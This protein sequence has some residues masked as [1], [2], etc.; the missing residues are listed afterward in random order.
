M[1]DEIDEAFRPTEAN[2]CQADARLL[3]FCRDL[4]A[5]T[6]LSSRYALNV[7]N[8]VGCGSAEQERNKDTVAVAKTNDS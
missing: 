7:G 4:L 1:I 2:E 5:P 3:S 8:P 6:L